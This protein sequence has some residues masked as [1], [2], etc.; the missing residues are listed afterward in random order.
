MNHAT[1]LSCPRLSVTLA[2]D[3]GTFQL[4]ADGFT[5]MAGEMAMITGPSGSGKSLFLELVALV[6]RPAVGSSFGMSLG[7]ESADF[8]RLTEIEDNE[9]ELAEF[10]R[11]IFGFVPQ[12]GELLPFLSVR[13][14][15][16]LTQR[17]TGCVDDRYITELLGRLDLQNAAQKPLDKLSV[18][19]RQ[20][21]AI[22]RALAHRPRLIL[23]DEPTAA[24]DPERSENV[25]KLLAE[26]SADIR[27]AVIFSTHDTSLAG[28]ADFSHWRCETQDAVTRLTQVKSATSARTP[29]RA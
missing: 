6:R 15:I 26:L 25:V 19:Q 28:L 13:E 24:L 7:S 29:V 20:R 5:L 9:R 21:V 1:L 22:A 16:A 11:R 2:S 10:R 17:M 27:T 18:G 14:N 4:I 23:A 3:D 12:S 8:S